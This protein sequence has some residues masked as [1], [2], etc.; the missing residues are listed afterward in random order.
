MSRFDNLLE[1][2][3]NT[4]SKKIAV[5]AAQDE[6][7]LKAVKAAAEE[8]IC[9]PIL[10]GDKEKIIE[11]S[12][13]I[14]FDL[15][16]I[17][18]IETK[19]EI[20]AA[21]KAVSMVSSGQADI[22]MK[23]LIDTSLI[24]KAVLDK[25]IGLRTGN[26]L[27]HAA[28]FET[29]KYHKLFILT[30]AAMNI[31]PNALEKKQIIENT[32]PLC[33]S[34]NIEN[35]KVAVI[36]AKEKVTDKMQATLDAQILVDMYEAGQ[37]KGCIIE[38]PFGLDNAI[39]KEAAATK[40]VKGEVA[41]DADVLLMPNIEAGNVMYKTLTYLADSKNAGIILGARAPIVLTSRADSDEAKLYSI[42]LGVICS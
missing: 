3:K 39:S 22:V 7:V 40:G 25:E 36:C 30:D 38:G 28:V 18:I 15:E 29:D 11:L 31:A 4:K 17:Q 42:L 14:N 10:I 1:L 32:L 19:D 16:G 2:A 13:G 26:I 23:G 33:R 27:N 41:G 24:L 21:R 6:D 9:I 5:A 35:P 8:K 37:I 12:Q 20:E 34:L